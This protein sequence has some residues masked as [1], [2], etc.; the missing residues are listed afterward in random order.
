MKYLEDY[1]NKVKSKNQ[2]LG[3]AIAKTATDISEKYIKT[4]SYREHVVSLLLG[5]IQSGKTSHMFGTMCAAADEGFG[6]FL[7]LTTDS[8]LLQQQ[9][10]V[11]AQNDLDNFFVCGEDDYLGFK[12]NNMRK[13]AVIVVKKN[14]RILKQWKNNL[15]ATDFAKVIRCLL[16]MMKQMQRV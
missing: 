15:A 9:T 11:R 14:P 2:S 7:L 1:L 12:K 16:S 8:I 3:E 13:P 4:F 5:E 6:I 10:L